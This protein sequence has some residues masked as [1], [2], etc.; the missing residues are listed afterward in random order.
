MKVINPE[1]IVIR[2]AT[3]EDTRYIAEIKVENHHAGKNNHPLDIMMNDLFVNAYRRRWEKRLNSG[4]HTLV[5]ALDETI[6]G[7]ISYSACA[8]KDADSA[9]AEITNIYL[10]QEVRGNKLGRKLCETAFAEMRTAG[11]ATVRVWVAKGRVQTRRFY[12]AIG[13]RRT[14]MKRIDKISQDV[15]MHEFKYQRSLD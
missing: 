2:P 3:L 10:L 1:S 8:D 15:I 11:F 5:L 6:S 9:T 7:L 4:K 12:E 14:T 13:F